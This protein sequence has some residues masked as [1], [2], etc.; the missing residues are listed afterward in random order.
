VVFAQLSKN[1]ENA[2]I[3]ARRYKLVA[4]GIVIFLRQQDFRDRGLEIRLSRAT[5][6]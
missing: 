3:K 1:L 6:C 2:C 4:A 5:A